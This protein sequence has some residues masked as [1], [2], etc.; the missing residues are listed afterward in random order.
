MAER[1]QSRS[2]RRTERPKKKTPL[3]ALLKRKRVDFRPDKQAVNWTRKFHITRAQRD[4]LLKWGGY[5]L[6]CILLLVIQDVIMSRI[7]L[8]GTTTDL[9]AS[10]IL[11]ITVMEGIS[12]GSLFVMLASLLYYFSGSAPG[13]YCVALMT[14]LGIGACIFRQLYWHRS[15]GS[16]VLSAGVALMLYEMITFGIG[17]FV[18][19][20]Y[21]GRITAFAFTGL[22]S[23]A[24]MLL[25]YPLIHFL[26]QIGGNTWKE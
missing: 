24:I 7:S 11:L 25:L 13:P 21:W 17:I 26:G 12:S 19:L 10:V 1:K 8:F 3:A 4:T 2:R 22:I 6:L 5:I 14:V 16:I 9:M 18:G 23:W 20:T 15:R